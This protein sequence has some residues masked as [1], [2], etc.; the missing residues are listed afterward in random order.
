MEQ[1]DREKALIKFRNGTHQL[2]VATD[3]AAR[4]IDVPEIKFIL[5][6]QLPHRAEDFV[7]RNG[8]T[9]RMNQS[10]TAYV[11]HWEQETLPDFIQAD[12]TEV[13]KSAPLPAPSPW[14]TLYISGGRR[15]KISK[16]DI[17]GLFFKKGGL[18]KGQL[19]VIEIKPECAYVAV[20]SQEVDRLINQLN[21]QRLK[22]KKVRLSLA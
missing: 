11:L 8:R 6:Y 21:N 13:L 9:A 3:L 19:G 14:T 5:H 16:G 22:K 18:D 10:G 17:A 7:H 20:D 1:R 12:A 15:D 2:L 4:G